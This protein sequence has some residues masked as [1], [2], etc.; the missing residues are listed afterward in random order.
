[1]NAT[2]V[3][4]DRRAALVEAAFESIARHGF[5]GLRLREVAGAAGI[6]HSTIHHHFATKQDLIEAVVNRATAPLYRTI[7][8][9]SSACERLRGHVRILAEMMETEPDLFVVLAEIDLRARRDAQ[10]R[11]IIDRVEQ[12]WRFG[13]GQLLDGDTGLV[14]L[15]IAVVKG[16]RLDPP[17]ARAVL[18]RTADLIVGDEV[19]R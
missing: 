1:M 2:Q 16:V 19:E 12:G 3:P 11:A 15:V 9:G 13:L 14:E 17:A 5:E 10:V 7:P 18:E 8:S 6:D 4:I